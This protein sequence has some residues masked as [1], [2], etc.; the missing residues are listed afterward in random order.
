MAKIVIDPGHGGHDP[1]AVGSRSKEKDNVLNVAKRLKTLLEDHGH[2]VSLT[3]ST[4]K[5]ISLSGR[6][7]F[8]NQLGADYFVSLHNNSAVNKLA[9]GFETFIY[10]GSVSKSTKDF[11]NAVHEEIANNIGI[12]DRGKKRA[13]FAVLRLTNM[14][15]ILIEYA[16]ISNMNDED[17]LIN[18]VD[19]LA[20]WTCNGIVKALGG[21]VKDPVNSPP[22]EKPT[23]AL[24]LEP[25]PAPR[26]AHQPQPQPKP[27][28]NKQPSGNANIKKFQ[29]WLNSQYNGGLVVDG[30][31]GPRTKKAAIKGFQTELNKQFNAGL[32]VDGIWGPKTRAA[33]VN[34]YKGAKGNLTKNIQGMLFSKGYDPKYLDGVF[35]NATANA[36]LAFQRD[37]GL[38][39]D[40]IVG[41]KTFE[42]L[43]A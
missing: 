42:K 37:N 23:P 10:N 13:N 33:T 4:D 41:K 16:F 3:R 32:N 29:Q 30:I 26:P 15:A 21:T 12:R 39:R 40:G 38:T 34:V 11:Q 35:G 25:E 27:P 36:V 28:Q 2:D 1:G 5:F 31:Y 18:Q 22:K 19:E 17:I 20:Q 9:T 43:F 14:A 24:K 6:A 8:A 7:S